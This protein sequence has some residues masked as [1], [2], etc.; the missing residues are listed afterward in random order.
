MKIEA[1]RD[2]TGERCYKQPIAGVLNLSSLRL[3]DMRSRLQLETQHDRYYHRTR[4]QGINR[5]LGK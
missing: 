4:I 3:R 1:K 5:S 2:L